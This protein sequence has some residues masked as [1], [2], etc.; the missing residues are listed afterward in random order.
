MREETEPNKSPKLLPPSEALTASAAHGHSSPSGREEGTLG[1]ELRRDRRGGLAWGGPAPRRHR[2]GGQPARTAALLPPGAGTLPA[3]HR[4]RVLR[5]TRAVLPAPARKPIYFVVSLLRAHGRDRPGRPARLSTGSCQVSRSTARRNLVCA[6]HRGIAG[7]SYYSLLK[8]SE[9]HA[10]A[11]GRTRKL[12]ASRRRVSDSRH[13]GG[14]L[15][16]IGRASG[17]TGYFP[18][19]P[20]V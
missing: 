3:G 10:Q 7:L 4:E 15:R 2:D 14:V 6:K 1:G 20:L 16:G 17:G 11:E 5:V 8:S 18:K 13:S 19:L 9:A 12:R